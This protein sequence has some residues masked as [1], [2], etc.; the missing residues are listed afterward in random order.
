MCIVLLCNIFQ[1]PSELRL[2]L[3]A[4]AVKKNQAWIFIKLLAFFCHYV[5]AYS[6]DQHLKMHILTYT[7]TSTNKRTVFIDLSL[8]HGLRWCA[9]AHS[10]QP[11]RWRQLPD[12]GEK[13]VMRHHF[14]WYWDIGENRKPFCHSAT[15]QWKPG[16]QKYIHSSTATTA[17]DNKE[18]TRVLFW[19]GC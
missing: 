11:L 5:S 1:L 10:F 15:D 16:W 12:R 2:S 18:M 6:P 8:L 19:H 3:H 14:G 9:G 13:W 7:H 4:Y 17:A